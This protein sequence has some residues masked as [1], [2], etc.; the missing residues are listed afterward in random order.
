MKKQYTTGMDS[1]ESA[2]DSAM[3]IAETLAP[4]S[5]LL[6]AL[7]ALLERRNRTGIS[8]DL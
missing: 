8:Y 1:Q 7:K 5:P 4:T 2:L 3:K 6:S